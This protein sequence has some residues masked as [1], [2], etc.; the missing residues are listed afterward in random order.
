MKDKY[1]RAYM[2][3]AE[4]F[5]QTSEA[6]RL[7]VGCLLVK[8]SGVISEGVNG[9]PPGW[10]TEVC[11]DEDDNTLDT[12]R[13]AEVAALEKMQN[14]TET[15]KGSIAFISHSPCKF[16]AIKLASAGVKEV[17]FRHTYR[18]KEGIEYLNFNNVLVRQIDEEGN[19]TIV[20]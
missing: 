12:V 18:S 3:M 20:L 5:G 14:K 15:V 2:D 8:D 17:C 10:Y 16:C 1:K 9:Q 7:K 4:R 13:H 19:I 11:E 6:K